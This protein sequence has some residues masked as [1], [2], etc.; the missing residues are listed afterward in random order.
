VP[1]VIV[2]II[3]IVTVM[4]TA[5]SIVREKEIGNMEQLMITPIRPIELILGKTIPFAIVG[6]LDMILITMAG[7]LVFRIP[8]RGS[9]FLL[10]AAS[11]LFL[12]TTLG[13]GLFIST[14][15]QT[16]Q[17][18]L[19][20]TFFFTM[21][22]FLL[23]GF[24]FPIRNMPLPVRCLTF[25]NP[26]RYFMEIVRGIFLKG[27]GIAILCHDIGRVLTEQAIKEDNQRNHSRRPPLG[28]P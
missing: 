24:A 13:T 15:S 27:T 16:Q 4:L 1:G 8:L 9:Y 28:D 19:M 25:L 14:I 2:N 6:L 3:A 12:M 23:S 17:Q 5:M 7:L 20:S 18:A 21:P 11:I 22:A 10:L 26:L